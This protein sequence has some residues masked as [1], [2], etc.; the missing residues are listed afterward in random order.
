MQ[1]LHSAV[2]EPFQ[3]DVVPVHPVVVVV[4]TE[5]GIQQSEQVFQLPMAIQFAPF[6]KLFQGL[7]ELFPGGPALYSILAGPV[8]A[9]VELKAQKIEASRLSRVERNH[10]CLGR[11]EA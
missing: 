1:A 5:F 6:R 7:V 9:P 4:P 3:T 2:V 10:P 8:F 11:R